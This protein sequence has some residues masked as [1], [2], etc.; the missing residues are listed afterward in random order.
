MYVQYGYLHLY[1]RAISTCVYRD[2]ER[3][4]PVLRSFEGPAYRLGGGTLHVTAG[5]MVAAGLSAAGCVY[6]FSQLFIFSTSSA[7]QSCPLL[8]CNAVWHRFTTAVYVCV[9]GEPPLFLV[10]AQ[11]SFL[12]RAKLVLLTYRNEY[13]TGFTAAFFPLSWS[14]VRFMSVIH[15]I[16][17]N[18]QAFMH[19]VFYHVY[20]QHRSIPSPPPSLSP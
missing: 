8:S 17:K 3:A 19:L 20:S 12:Y 15:P 18:E 13:W 2:T 11:T 16:A 6:F 7:V 9:Y 1:A 14:F 4:C 10:N 5:G